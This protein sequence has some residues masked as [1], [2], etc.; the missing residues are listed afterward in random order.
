[1]S[2]IPLNHRCAAIDA[3]VVAVD[4]PCRDHV[5]IE[6]E[7]EAFPDSMPG[8]FLELRCN[9]EFDSWQQARVWPEGAFPSLQD[10]CWLGRVPYLRRP[11][12]IADRYATSAGR[13]RLVVLSRRIGPGTEF[14]DQL[15]V[16]GS[17]NITGPLGNGFVV[18]EADRPMLLVG[19]GVGIPPLLYLARAL[20]AAGRRSVTVVFGAMSAD[21][22]PVPQT[23]VPSVEGRPSRCLTLPGE[24]DF[25]AVVTTDDGTLGLKGRV[26]D[27]L[28]RLAPSYS[29][30]APWVA[31]CGPEGMLHGVA[32]LTRE[33]G[34]ECQLCIERNM[35]CGVG[36]CLS[37]VTRVFDA[38]RPGGV[39]W[40][41]TCSEGPVFPRDRLVDFGPGTRCAKG[42]GEKQNP[43]HA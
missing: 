8:Q 27:A 22:M 30:A 42:G 29:G 26:T 25:P 14:L 13:V 31:A 15:H 7:L 39:R 23:A 10:P 18:P 34:W 1:M 3:S 19:G 21:L 12:S 16:G 17:L 6:L 5:R 28:R 35:G 38:T 24:A 37:C 43:E 33:F 4:H 36:T 20:H 40:A 2:A 41:L 11:F 9:R 32:N